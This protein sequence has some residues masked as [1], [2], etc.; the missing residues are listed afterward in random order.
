MTLPPSLFFPF[1]IVNAI[2]QAGAGSYLQTSVVAIA[3]LFGP[4]TM[5][6]V[7]SGQAAVAIVV[8]SV[9]VISA[10]ASLRTSSARAAA[11]AGNGDTEARSAFIFF[12][13]STVFLVA[14][15]GANVWLT[16]MPAFRAI[17][18]PAAGDEP[19]YARARS[20]SVDQSERRPLVSD[21]ADL[22]ASGVHEHAHIGDKKSRILRI[23]KKN[24]LYELAVAYVFVITLVSSPKVY[25]ISMRC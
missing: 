10:S 14:T 5:Q 11:I 16:R 13:L 17:V 4:A 2:A 22:S 18:A 19:H 1:V 9:Q 3:S 8:S 6:A 7:M 21:A 20:L 15:A 23:A 24:V 25:V 12:A